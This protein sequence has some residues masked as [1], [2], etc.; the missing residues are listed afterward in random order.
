MYEIINLD[1][2]LF[3]IRVLLCP[4]IPNCSLILDIGLCIRY[5]ILK[6]YG[7]VK[8]DINVKEGTHLI[9]KDG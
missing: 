8:L 7:R 2:D 9:E 6:E 3:V 1:K 5:V 4:T